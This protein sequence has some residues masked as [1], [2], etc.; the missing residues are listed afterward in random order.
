MLKLWGYQTVKKSY[1]FS[2]FGTIPAVTDS[3]PATQTRCCSKDTT[4][5]VARVNID[6]VYGAIYRI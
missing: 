2:G 4:Y 6:V 5:Y 3:K 1:R